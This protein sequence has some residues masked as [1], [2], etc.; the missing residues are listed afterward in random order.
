MCCLTLVIDRHCSHIAKYYFQSNSSNHCNT[1][2]IL[3]PVVT[4]VAWCTLTTCENHIAAEVTAVFHWMLY[5]LNK[6]L[7]TK[8]IMQNNLFKINV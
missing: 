2:G 3:L 8:T 6:N 5:H 4:Y 7:V 1:G